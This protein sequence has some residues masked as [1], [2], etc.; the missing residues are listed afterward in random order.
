[1]KNLHMI[2]IFCSFLMVIFSTFGCK[3]KD[4]A[5][6][7][8]ETTKKEIAEIKKE[9]KITEEDAIAEALSWVNTIDTG[10]Y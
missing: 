1:M 5:E 4:T 2:T 9:C 7:T 3:N 6:L 8:S 10:K